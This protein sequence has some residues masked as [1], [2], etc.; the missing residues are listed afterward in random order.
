V[1]ALL[2]EAAE[3]HPRVY[4][5]VEGDDPDWADRLIRLSELPGIAGAAPVRSV[6]VYLLVRLD[7]E[8]TVSRP[9]QPWESYYARAVV[10]TI[11]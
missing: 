5:V 3:T 9:D 7:R 4:R 1:A 10:A 2:R 6:L 11:R 8:Y